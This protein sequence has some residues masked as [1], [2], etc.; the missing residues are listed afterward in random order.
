MTPTT[1]CSSKLWINSLAARLTRERWS[2]YAQPR[3]E[4]LP[5]K[6]GKKEARL[7]RRKRASA[8]LMRHS[9][10]LKS[11]FL[12]ASPHPGFVYRPSNVPRR[13]PFIRER[14]LN[15]YARILVIIIGGWRLAATTPAA[16]NGYPPD[17][18]DA[19]VQN[20]LQ[21]AEA[22]LAEWAA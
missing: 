9:L 2:C 7:N 5:P 1:C 11:I 3:L 19:A 4:M 12:M 21:Q 8:G 10:L 17:L 18:Q 20:V 22:L 14:L 13:F 16:F 6:A 15:N